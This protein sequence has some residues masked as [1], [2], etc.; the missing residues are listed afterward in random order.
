[1]CNTLNKHLQT[2]RW[3]I[4]LNKRE[5]VAYRTPWI[6]TLSSH[7]SLNTYSQRAAFQPKP[8]D[9]AVPLNPGPV[10]SFLAVTVCLFRDTPCCIS[11]LCLTRST[12]THMLTLPNTPC[13]CLSWNYVCFAEL[14]HRVSHWPLVFFFHRLP[15]SH[16]VTTLCSGLDADHGRIW[17]C[18]VLNVVWQQSVCGRISLP[19]TRLF[20]H[21]F[22]CAF[23]LHTVHSLPEAPPPHP[24][25]PPSHPLFYTVQWRNAPAATVS[26]V[27]YAQISTLDTW[28][29]GHGPGVV[30][31]F[32]SLLPFFLLALYFYFIFFLLTLTLTKSSASGFGHLTQID[33][34]LSQKPGTL[35]PGHVA[36]SKKSKAVQNKYLH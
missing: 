25:T 20:R 7:L 2:Y 31:T 19:G 21:F 15:L 3:Q 8:N 16:S 36:C 29:D 4:F 32:S 30:E 14:I 6:Q 34:T 10:F 28:L 12:Q 23:M 35:C 26:T 9:D 22:F 13:W 27:L 1:M 17:I 5:P 11:Q 24:L 33:R 18:S